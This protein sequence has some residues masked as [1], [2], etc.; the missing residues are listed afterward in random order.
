MSSRIALTEL[1][2]LHSSTYLDP[3]LSIFEN[4]DIIWQWTLWDAKKLTEC[5]APSSRI[6]IATWNRRS[7]GRSSPSFKAARVSAGMWRS[8]PQVWNSSRYMR[9][10]FIHS[11]YGKLSKSR[12]EQPLVYTIKFGTRKRRVLCI[13]YRVYRY[14][15]D[16]TNSIHDNF[17]FAI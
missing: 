15:H 3:I 8:V 10:L 4:S 16:P 12:M 1:A 7:F 14:I 6:R 5:P 9:H 11:E 17:R 13:V 2:I